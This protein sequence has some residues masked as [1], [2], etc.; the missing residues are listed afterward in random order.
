MHNVSGGSGRQA[1]RAGGTEEVPRNAPDGTVAPH[2]QKC[3][4]QLYFVRKEENETYV[5]Q[6]KTEQGRNS[7]VMFGRAVRT[8]G[9]ETQFNITIRIEIKKGYGVMAR[10]NDEALTRALEAAIKEFPGADVHPVSLGR[11]VRKMRKRHPRGPM[12]T[13]KDGRQMRIRDMTDQHLTNAIL[14]R[15][16]SAEYR[17]ARQEL[18]MTWVSMTLQGEMAQFYLDRD[19]DHLMSMSI[20][21]YLEDDQTYQDLLKDA[22]RRRIPLPTAGEWG[23]RGWSDFGGQRKNA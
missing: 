13:T 19:L 14:S 8:L 20:E 6:C 18:E 21:Q 2:C 1:K 3:G 5:W 10:S 16:R 9:T 17:K 22:R 7:C 12:W 11:V 23:H 15:E 4:Q